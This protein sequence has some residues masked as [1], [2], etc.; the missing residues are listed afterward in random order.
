MVHPI[1]SIVFIIAQCRDDFV[2]FESTFRR[3]RTGRL[4]YVE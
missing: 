3:Q 1:G 2:V 4:H